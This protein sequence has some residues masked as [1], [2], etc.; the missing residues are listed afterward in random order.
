MARG[1]LLRN[2]FASYSRH[3]DHGFR[4]IALEIIAEEQQKHNN[5]LARDLL[6]M[7][8][9]PPTA[10]IPRPP[11][12][13]F[14]ESPPHSKDRQT[15]LADVRHPS[16]TL[17]DLVLKEKP[18]NQLLRILEEYRKT[19]LLKI[20]G[21]RPKTKLLF[22]GPSGCGKSLCAEVIATELSL[23]LLYVRFDAIVS[24][25]LGET[26]SNIRTIFDYAASGR[27]VVLL[28]EFDAVGKSRN[29]SSEHGELKRVVSSFL[30]LLDSFE[31]RSF[32]IAATNHENLLDSALWRRFDE[33]LPFVLPGVPEIQ[34]L[35]SEKLKN[36][37]Q[38]HID[39]EKTA[40]KLRGLSHADVEWVC[41]D[42][43][44][45]AILRDTEAVTKSI[46][47]ESVARQKE[48]VHAKGSGK[49]GSHLSR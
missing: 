19:E 28:D 22:Y 23:P 27:W 43:I 2:L 48:R 40:K 45:T 4:T 11:S 7:I 30:Q 44:K 24:S 15:L 38:D 35:L 46:L 1:E 5:V 26:S 41:F 33:I 34:T 8:E 14:L 13:S 42:A 47:D 32:I 20:H 6:N 18:R 21:L 37:P 3:D 39:F 36:F 12:K 25:Y 29:D 10:K 16:R 17:S 9:H 49:S 31:G